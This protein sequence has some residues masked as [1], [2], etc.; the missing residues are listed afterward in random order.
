[1]C[2]YDVVHVGHKSIFKSVNKYFISIT[3]TI[4]IISIII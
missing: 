1:M 4:I 2:C 3:I